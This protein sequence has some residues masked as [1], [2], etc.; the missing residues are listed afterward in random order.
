[1]VVNHDLHSDSCWT[2]G[3]IGVRCG[4]IVGVALQ[5]I[6]VILALKSTWRGFKLLTVLTFIVVYAWAAEAVGS[7][8][9]F[10]FGVYQYTDALQ[11]QLAGVPL[12][13]PFAWL[14]MLPP[15]WAIARVLTSPGSRWRFAVLS[16]GAMTA[17]DL[18]LDP[19]MVAWGYWA[20]VQEGVYFGIPLQNYFGWL[21]VSFI[22]SLLVNPDEMNNTLLITIYVLTWLLES[23]GLA[24]FWDLPEP[25]LAGFFGMGI[26][27]VAA[28]AREFRRTPPLRAAA[29]PQSPSQS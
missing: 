10:P 2:V 24:F 14:M 1:M 7:M 21:L 13:I 26:F 18:F 15:S 6:T 22:I 23:V 27:S 5:V 9:G 16:A 19:Q 12:L 20:W 17:W 28:V 8:T 11:P 4:T 29:A 3:E 25:A